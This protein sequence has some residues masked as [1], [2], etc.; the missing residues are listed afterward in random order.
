[1]YLSLMQKQCHWKSNIAKHWR[2][3][4]EA[5][6]Q[7]LEVD[8]KQCYFIVYGDKLTMFRSYYG[9]VAVAKKNGAS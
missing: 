3:I 6:L 8:K 1:M 5:T 4:S 9:D 7:G 2:G